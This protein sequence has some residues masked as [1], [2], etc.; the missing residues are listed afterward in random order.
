MGAGI[1]N[2]TV[3]SFFMFCMCFLCLSI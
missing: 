1:L 3:F 2:S